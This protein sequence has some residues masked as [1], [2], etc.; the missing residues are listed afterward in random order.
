[1]K[2]AKDIT[3][4]KALAEFYY[5]QLENVRQHLQEL[6][7]ET[8]KALGGIICITWYNQNSQIDIDNGRPLFVAFDKYGA[9]DMYIETIR[10]NEVGAIVF[11]L[12]NDEQ[13]CLEVRDLTEFSTSDMTSI[14]T[15]LFAIEEYNKE[16]NI[17]TVTEL[18]A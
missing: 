7:Q 8:V 14:L 18:P 12:A 15:M 17:D 2:K 3:I 4:R 10:V 16:N 13:T 5:Q 6:I 9:V 11:T 1:M